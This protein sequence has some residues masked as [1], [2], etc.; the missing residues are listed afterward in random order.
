MEAG[1]ISILGIFA[2]ISI[3]I[4]AFRGILSALKPIARFLNGK[5]TPTPRP[6]FRPY[7]SGS[8]R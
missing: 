1:I 7:Y 6:A 3:W 2:F 8:F 5:H 4:I